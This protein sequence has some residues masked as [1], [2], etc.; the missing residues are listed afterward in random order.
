MSFS[1][2]RKQAFRVSSAPQPS[3]R[4]CLEIDLNDAGRKRSVSLDFA[5]RSD[6]ERQLERQLA[7][8]EKPVFGRLMEF[9]NES[10]ETLAVLAAI[11]AD[12]RI[13]EI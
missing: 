7:L 4:W 12:H 10:G 9:F 6:L 2:F 5:D 11:Y 8:H 13:S 3:P 1:L